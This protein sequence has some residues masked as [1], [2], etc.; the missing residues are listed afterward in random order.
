MWNFEPCHVASGMELLDNMLIHFASLY[1]SLSILD[2]HLL[3]ANC[4][5]RVI[6]SSALVCKTWCTG[7]P[8]KIQ[9]LQHDD[10][11]KDKIGGLAVV[12]PTISFLRV[13]QIEIEAPLSPGTNY[14]NCGRICKL[15]MF[16]RTTLKGK[17]V[18]LAG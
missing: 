10:E 9:Q 16:L 6:E 15:I 3:A 11:S 12:K 7:S 14:G 8:R 5:T 13:S 17:E 4:Q 18:W 1:I 2:V